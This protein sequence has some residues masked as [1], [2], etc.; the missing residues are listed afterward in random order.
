MPGLDIDLT[1]GSALVTGGGSGVGTEICRAL[2]G[3]G[4]FVW[5]N[6]IYEDRA[7]KVAADLGGD[8]RTPG[9]SRPTS[10]ARS[11]SRACARRPG[12]STSSSTTPAIPTQGFELKRFVDTDPT[13]GST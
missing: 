7:A 2:V 11:R 8:G 12:R 6:D 9:R 1:G 13:T 3:A 5:V 10:R 4:A